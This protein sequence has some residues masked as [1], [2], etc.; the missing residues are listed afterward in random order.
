MKYVINSFLVQFHFSPLTTLVEM[1]TK[2][3][4]TASSCG[5]SGGDVI[6]KKLLLEK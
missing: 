6:L 2:F 4:A 3:C 5:G 1:A